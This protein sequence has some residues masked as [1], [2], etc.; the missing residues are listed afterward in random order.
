MHMFISQED[1]RTN[2]LQE[3]WVLYWIW[4][5]LG[6]PREVFGRGSAVGFSATGHF[7]SWS[8][9]TRGH[10]QMVCSN[11]GWWWTC[12]QMLYQIGTGIFDQKEI[13]TCPYLHYDIVCLLE[14]GVPWSKPHAWSIP[15]GRQ[16][17][18]ELF[19]LFSYNR[20]AHIVGHIESYLHVILIHPQYIRY[21][22]LYTPKML[23]YSC[24]FMFILL[25][26]ATQR[27]GGWS[28]K[29]YFPSWSID[30][31]IPSHGA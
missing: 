22:P 2:T 21:I 16:F 11:G 28:S 4:F 31:L 1:Q 12:W 13:S 15:L 6:A 7:A 27:D 10:Q 3:F 23:V 9:A 18:G 24:M 25:G 19:P 30:I 14:N 8:D 26:K 29:S 20:M 5:N 17:Y